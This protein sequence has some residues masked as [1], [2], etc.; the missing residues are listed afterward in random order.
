MPRRG[1]IACLDRAARKCPVGADV[2]DEVGVAMRI[3]VVVRRTGVSCFVLLHGAG[4]TSWYWHLVAPRLAAAGHEVVAVDLPVDDDSAGL[5]AYVDTVVAAIEDRRDV[6]LVGQSLAGF[7]APVVCTRT[8]V[9]LL[10]LVAAMVP[11]PGERLGE[12]WVDTGHDQ[13]DISVDD[14]VALFLHDVPPEVASA[15]EQHLRAQSGRVFEDVWPLDAWPDITTR[16]LI[17]AQDRFF[18]PE[19]QRRVARERLGLEP[20][21]MPGGHLPALARPDD[22]AAR[23][24]AY[25]T[26]TPDR[27][28]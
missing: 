11:K 17:C 5:D 9:E 12:W 13:L 27:A 22:L 20:D 19:F 21:E 16:A 14:P 23:L 24:L 3:G 6:V 8:P 1:S 10:V 25:D 4:S 7:V 2:T 15:S 26:A 18:P 28:S